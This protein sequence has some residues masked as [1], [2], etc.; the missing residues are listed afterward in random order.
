MNKIPFKIKK[1]DGRVV[2]YS[3]TRIATS[4]FKAAENVGGEDRE[5]RDYRCTERGRYNLKT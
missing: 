4:I 1:R 5:S 2:K 3:K